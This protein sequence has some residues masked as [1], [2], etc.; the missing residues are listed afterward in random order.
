MGGNWHP[1]ASSNPMSSY[2]ISQCCSSDLHGQKVGQSPSFHGIHVGAFW[3]PVYSSN[4]MSQ[5]CSSG[6]HGQF[7]GH[8]YPSLPGAPLVG[9]QIGVFSHPMSL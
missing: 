3:Q 4:P 9:R 8:S 2:P 1:M 7:T 5:V 6:I